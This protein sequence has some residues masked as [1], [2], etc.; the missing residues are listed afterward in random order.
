MH[1]FLS[2][3]SLLKIPFCSEV[4]DKVYNCVSVHHGFLLLFF[5]VESLC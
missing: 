1:V 4:A 2:H 5:Q 3:F